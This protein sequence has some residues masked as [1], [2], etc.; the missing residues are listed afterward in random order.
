M[1][2]RVKYLQVST[3]VSNRTVSEIAILGVLVLH[4]LVLGSGA[5]H[6]GGIGKKLPESSSMSSRANP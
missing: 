1:Y 3:Y 4:G 2:E 5:G 6:R